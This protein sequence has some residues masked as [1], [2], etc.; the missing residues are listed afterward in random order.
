MVAILGQDCSLVIQPFLDLG[1]CV[2]TFVICFVLYQFDCD[3]YVDVF[4]VEFG[5]F[6][7]YFGS[8]QLIDLF[9]SRC[10]SFKIQ[11]T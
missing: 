8:Y 5:D 11:K 2:P 7:L 6:Y 4:L 9:W 10:C 3:H 1:I